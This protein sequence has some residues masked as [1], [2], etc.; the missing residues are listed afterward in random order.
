MFSR[1]YRDMLVFYKLN[2]PFAIIKEVAKNNIILSWL[3]LQHILNNICKN[4]LIVVASF[5]YVNFLEFGIVET[6]FTFLLLINF[7]FFLVFWVLAQY[8]NMKLLMRGIYFIL[9]I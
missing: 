1:L 8:F 6:W 2:T 4:W 5:C 9:H 7:I 3:L